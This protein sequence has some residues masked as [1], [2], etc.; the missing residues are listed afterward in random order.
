MLAKKLKV[1][2]GTDRTLTIHVPDITPGEVELII[3][4]EEEHYA[5]VNEILSQM[6][7]HRAGKVLSTLTRENIYTNAR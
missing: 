3:L 4:K 5:T 6:P 2:I 1:R 7:K